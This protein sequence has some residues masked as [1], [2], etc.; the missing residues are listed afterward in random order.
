MEA[1]AEGGEAREGE[2]EVCHRGRRLLTSVERLHRMDRGHHV[3]RLRLRRFFSF[4]PWRGSFGW[5][6]VIVW[7]TS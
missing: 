6:F 4:V 5:W 3:G 1:V 2:G 7:S